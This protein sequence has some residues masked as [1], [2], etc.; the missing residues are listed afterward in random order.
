MS[1]V[2]KFPKWSSAS[3]DMVMSSVADMF[4]VIDIV[5]GKVPVHVKFILHTYTSDNPRNIHSI[6]GPPLI[7]STDEKIGLVESHDTV[8]VSCVDLYT[9]VHHILNVTV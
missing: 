1:S 8:M 6:A 4:S 7:C 9:A 5:Q 3:T 2:A